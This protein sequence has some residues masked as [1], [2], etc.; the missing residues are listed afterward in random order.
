M[1][2][3]GKLAGTGMF[4]LAGLAATHKLD[5]LAKPLGGLARSGAFGIAGL[6]ASRQHHNPAAQVP[7]PGAAPMP[8]AGDFQDPTAYLS[9]VQQWAQATQGALQGRVPGAPPPVPR[10]IGGAVQGGA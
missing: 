2:L 5:G 3:L 6:L 1:G 10:G 9:A 7:F 4:G 8:Q